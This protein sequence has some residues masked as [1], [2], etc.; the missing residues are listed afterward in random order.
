MTDTIAPK[1][2]KKDKML[3][4]AIF[5]CLPNIIFFIVFFIAPAIVGVWYSLTDFNGLRR[6]NFVGMEN[7]F[8]LFRD[9]EFY[10]ILLNT[11]KYSI[12]AV[13]L[14]YIAALGLA[15]LLSS[16]ALRNSTLLRILI[17]W[18]TLIS[19]IMVGLTWRWIF[20]ENFGILNYL[21]TSAGLSPINWATNPNAAF[22]TTIIA[23]IWAGCGTSMLIFIGGIAQIPQMLHE[24]AIIDGANKWQDFFYV[25][26]PSLKP[27]SF[28]VIILSTIGSFKVFAMVQTLT[29]GGPGTATTYMIQYIYST[30]FE[31]QRVGYS[32]AASIVLFLLLLI[33][34]FAQ[35]RI[36]SQD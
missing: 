31:K 23:G 24:A 1:V 29:N 32:S 3:K 17:Y 7:Y 4:W 22:A 21:L 2:R 5:F 18:P 13:P 14:G 27:V 9:P 36:N 15:L 10:D 11:F 12:F 20:G 30:G 19:T 16:N 26:L 8:Q 35:T 6:M 34:S 28:M 33:M 25:T